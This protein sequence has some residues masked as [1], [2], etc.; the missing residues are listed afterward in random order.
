MPDNRC[1]KTAAAFRSSVNMAPA[2]IRRWAADPRAKCASFPETRRRLPAL[3]ALREKAPSTW[4]GADCRFAAR[5]VSFNARMQGNVN[6]HGCGPRNVVSLLNWG[7]RPPGC[8]VPATCP[9]RAPRK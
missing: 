2:A 7:R 1:P 3:A 9:A 5:V 8:P 4:T 6:A